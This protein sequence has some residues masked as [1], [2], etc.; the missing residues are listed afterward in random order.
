MRAPV[1]QVH[2]EVARIEPWDDLEEAHRQETLQWLRATDDVYRRRKP[3][4]PDRHL[5]SYVAILDRDAMLLV[6]HL[7][8]GLWLPPGGHVE[9]GEPPADTARR[10]T[11]EELGIEADFRSRPPAPSFVTATRTV[12]AGQH[13]DVSLWF[14]LRGSRSGA[15]R[16]DETEFRS[17]RW[18]T[19][20]ELQA[21]D[22]ARFDP[23]FLR[24]VAK[25]SSG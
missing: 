10:E 3:H 18:W 11:W 7:A 14:L 9:P 16:L 8:A 22:P 13:V 15:L 20:D 6:D 1:Q 2:D 25:T 4:V 23:H 21:N 5:V 19:A 17:A 24:F 12:G